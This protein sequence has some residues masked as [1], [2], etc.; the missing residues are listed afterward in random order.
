MNLNRNQI[1]G[2]L[3]AVAGVLAASSAQLTD[4]F[5]VTAAK[6]IVSVC[7]LLSTVLGS[8]LAMI[9]GQ[10]GLVKQVQDMP[11]IEKILVNAQA[12]KTLASIAVDDAATKIEATPLAEAAVQRTAKN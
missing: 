8:V 3:I 5:G 6:T 9:T 10:G 1:L 12:N 7:S 2:I 11:G 4:I